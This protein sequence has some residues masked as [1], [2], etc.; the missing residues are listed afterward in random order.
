M[1]FGHRMRCNKFFSGKKHVTYIS[2]WS[3]TVLVQHSNYTYSVPFLFLKSIFFIRKSVPF[4]TEIRHA[5][6]H[7]PQSSVFSSGRYFVILI[8]LG[9]R[10]DW[11]PFLLFGFKDKNIRLITACCGLMSVSL[12]SFSGVEH[13][14][15]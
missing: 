3:Y 10:N 12:V 1:F 7:C 5:S 9:Y 4:G 2:C 11:K 8:L 6:V 15:V 13:Q 14:V